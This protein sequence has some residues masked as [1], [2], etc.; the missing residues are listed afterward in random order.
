MENMNTKS[1]TTGNGKFSAVKILGVCL[2]LAAI[3]FI[4]ITVFKLTPMNLVFAG[5]LLLCPLLHVWMMRG[6]GHKH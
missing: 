6:D 1:V 4:A 3:A 5:G 2:S